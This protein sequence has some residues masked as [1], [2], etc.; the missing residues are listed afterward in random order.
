[1]RS[2]GICTS[3]RHP[4][5]LNY[6]TRRL[7][8]EALTRYEAVHLIDP[9]AVTYAFVRGETRPGIVHRGED[10]STLTTLIV[11]STGGREAATAVLVRALKLC[12][13][14][15]FDPVERFALG[16]ASKLLTTLTRFQSGAGTSTYV[17]FSR[18]GAATLLRRLGA[19]GR[20]PLLLKPAAG[21]K[22]RGIH[23]VEDVDGGM[24]LLEEHFEFQE[25]TD[26]PFFLQDLVEF[27]K[28][29]RILVVDGAALGV[30]E[31]IRQPGALAANAAQGAWFVAADAPEVVRAALPHVSGEGIL[32]VDVAVDAAGEVH[33]IE[34]NRA[35]EWEAFE[36]A[37]GL[38]V[39]RLLIDRAI[40]RLAAGDRAGPGPMPGGGGTG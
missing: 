25:H 38:N 12:G 32:G 21:K 17:C 39:A 30:A 11:R 2:L 31:K 36:R 24:R 8:E 6:E 33:V 22:G 1:M 18:G 14:D 40:R 27:R 35:P 20:L 26:E 3:R 37:T 5:E 29:Y 28:E 23:V 15:V 10:I 4:D 19:E 16:K 34:A 7:Y 13:C 9:R